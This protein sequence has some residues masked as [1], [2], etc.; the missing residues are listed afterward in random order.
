ML[1]TT[2]P[3]LQAPGIFLIDVGRPNPQRVV[4]STLTTYVVLSCIKK[5]TEHPIESKSESS[6]SPG[7]LGTRSH[8]SNKTQLKYMSLLPRRWVL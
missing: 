1:L 8:N 5:L 6:G 4:P 2:E 3:S 7:L